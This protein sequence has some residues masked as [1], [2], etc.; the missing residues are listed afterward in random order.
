[1][2]SAAE[3]LASLGIEVGVGD[4]H[5]NI[6]PYQD[7]S[8][9]CEYPTPL[10]S[11]LAVTSAIPTVMLAILAVKFKRILGLYLRNWA[12]FAFTQ[13]TDLRCELIYKF[14][15]G[16]ETISSHTMI[17]G[18]REPLVIEEVPTT[19]EQVSGLELTD[20]VIG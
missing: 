2:S 9:T 12:T 13:R 19:Q 20:V 15:V 1:M 17:R 14:S 7:N 8:T 5:P 18:N 4:P 6:N 3:L 16:L 11:T 10:V